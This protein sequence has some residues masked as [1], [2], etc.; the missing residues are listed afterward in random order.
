MHQ[1]RLPGGRCG[2]VTVRAGV[3]DRTTRISFHD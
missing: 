3:K 1:Q 2:G